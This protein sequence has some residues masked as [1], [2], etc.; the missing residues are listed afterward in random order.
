[1]LTARASGLE[2]DKFIPLIE[3]GARLNFPRPIKSSLERI[4]EFASL[5]GIEPAGKPA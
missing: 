3:E 4:R 1:M 2:L 5:L